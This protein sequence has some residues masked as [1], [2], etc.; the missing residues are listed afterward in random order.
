M[1]KTDRKILFNVHQKEA[2][3]KILDNIG[4]AVII[5]ILIGIFVES[6]I[7][8]GNGIPLVILALTCFSV[9]VFLRRGE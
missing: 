7:D 9:G 8:F 6:K 5:A 2:I 4:T 3:A 1:S